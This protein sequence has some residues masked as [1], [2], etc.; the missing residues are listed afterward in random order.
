MQLHQQDIDAS[1]L[2]V[3]EKY[4]ASGS[5]VL[6]CSFTPKK[7]SSL[8]KSLLNNKR[9]LAAINSFML[10]PGREESSGRTRSR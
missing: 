9:I 1:S 7:A 10:H 5:I 4:R 3:H 2:R 6:R 8:L